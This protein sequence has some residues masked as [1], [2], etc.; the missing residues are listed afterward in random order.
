MRT[1]SITFLDHL[2]SH[3]CGNV[4]LNSKMEEFCLFPGHKQLA[5]HL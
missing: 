4:E 5:L 3:V 2:A 1:N